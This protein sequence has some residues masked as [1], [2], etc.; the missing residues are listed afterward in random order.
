[1]KFDEYDIY[2]LY[3]ALKLHYSSD[4]Y[5]AVK[6]RFKTNVKPQTFWKRK[7]RYFF[8]RVGVKLDWNRELILDYFNAYFSSDVVWVGSMLED[9]RI[10]TDQQK[11]LQSLQ[12]T[13]KNDIYN[14]H[15][16]YESFDD[17]FDIT[18]SPHPPIVVKL[19]SGDICIE[20][21]VILNKV[22]GFIPRLKINETMV[23]PDLKKRILKYG[24]MID[25]K[26]QTKVFK[27]ITLK[28][29]TS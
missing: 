1:M 9:E 13:F 28:E 17:L 6:Y 21:I 8:Y 23:W 19:L 24:L 25:Q 4:T 29:W 5:D 27:T 2:C 10:W 16:E 18:D 20:T 15:E 14:L 3:M 26:I 12:Y 11:K 7:D 22:L